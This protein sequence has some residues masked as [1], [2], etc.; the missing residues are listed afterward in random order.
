MF[1]MSK[2]LIVNCRSCASQYSIDYCWP[3]CLLRAYS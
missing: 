2:P 1:P 3:R